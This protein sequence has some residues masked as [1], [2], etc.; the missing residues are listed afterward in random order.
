MGDVSRIARDDAEAHE[1]A[2]IPQDRVRDLR[3]EL[4]D[5]LML[6]LHKV[7]QAKNSDGWISVPAAPRIF[8]VFSR[9]ACRS[10]VFCSSPS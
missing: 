2:R 5:V 10:A 8:P 4:I 7:F 1:H 9:D 3:V 6:A